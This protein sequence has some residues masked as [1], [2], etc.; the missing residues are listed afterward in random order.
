[1]ERRTRFQSL[2]LPATH[3]AFATKFPPPHRIS[4]GILIVVDAAEGV[5]CGTEKAIKIAA[6]ENLP[7][8]LFIN[9]IDRL[10]VELKLPPGETRTTN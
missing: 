9:K 6:R 8:V 4:D 5:M 3:E 2:I 10:I 1:M 7:C